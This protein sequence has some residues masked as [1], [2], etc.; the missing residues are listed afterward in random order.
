MHDPLQRARA[1]RAPR[2]DRLALAAL[3]VVLLGA[4]ALALPRVIDRRERAGPAVAAPGRERAGAGVAAPREDAPKRLYL[5]DATNGAKLIPLD[6]RTLANLA[7]R[8]LIERSTAS[9]GSC[10]MVVSADG[11]TIATMEYAYGGAATAGGLTIRVH[12]ARTGAERARFSPPL[13]VIV[14]GLSPDGSRLYARDWPPR[15]LGAGRHVLDTSDG[16]L[17]GAIPALSRCCLTRYWL[18]PGERR[19]HGILVPDHRNGPLPNGPQTP[20]LVAQDAA[21]GEEA[22]EVRLDGVLLGSW[23][24]DREVRGRRVAANLSPGIALSPDGRRIAILHAD[25]EALTLID[26]ARLQV[27]WTKPLSRPAGLLDRLGLRP[28]TASAKELESTGWELHFSPDGRRLYA[29][30]SQTRVAD[31]GELVE[32]GLGL[33]VIAFEDARII[34]EDLA[35]ERLFWLAPAADGDALYAFAQ[36]R[37]AAG[38]QGGYVLRRLDPRTLAVTAEREFTGLQRPYFLAAPA[39]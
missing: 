4:L 6:P 16:H 35:D 27:L 10:S 17:V 11:T 22:G 31:T 24:T 32:Q 36:R 9:C 13:P 34:A 23:Q 25:R 26:V 18:A 12:D 30:G 5:T 39:P 2:A 21:S 19:L 37:P 3:L 15:E 28:R 14:D 33:R 7:D 38:Q 20:L 1:T 8:P 29:A